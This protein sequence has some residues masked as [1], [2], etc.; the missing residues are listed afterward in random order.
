MV[1]RKRAVK[2]VNNTVEARERTHGNKSGT[3]DVSFTVD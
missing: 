2:M 3:T 1:D